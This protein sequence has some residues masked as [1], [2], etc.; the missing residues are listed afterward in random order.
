MIFFNTIFFLTFINFLFF[1]FGFFLLNIIKNQKQKIIS[2]F[3]GISII[4]IITNIFYF[5]LNFNISKIL[6][7]LIVVLLVISIINLKDKSFFNFFFSQ[8]KYFVPMFVIGSFLAFIYNEQFFIFRGNHYDSSNYT[9]MSLLF[10]K[11]SYFELKDI[12][13]NQE[14]FKNPFLK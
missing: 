11:F 5:I 1:S 12:Y 13:I 14:S 10:S 7:I 9:S 8:L 4:T 2:I 6:I 3:Y